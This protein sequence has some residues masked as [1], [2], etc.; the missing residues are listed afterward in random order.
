[1]VYDWFFHEPF[2]SIFLGVTTSLSLFSNGLLLYIVATTQSTHIG[3]YR[4]LL[5]VFAACDVTTAIG[6]AA[7]QPVSNFYM[8]L[9]PTGFYFF[10][11]HAENIIITE[12]FDTVFCLFF[13]ATYYQTFLILAYHFIYR[14]KT[15]TSGVSRSFTDGWSMRH[16]V[17]T[18]IVVYVLYIAGF[19]G[20][21]AIAFTPT[22]NSRYHR[23]NVPSEILDIYGIDLSDQRTG[24]TVISVK[25]WDS[26]LG[27]WEVHLPSILGLVLLLSLFGGTASAIVFCIYKTNAAIRS[28]DNH[29][30][31][32]TRKMQMGL[33]RA[34]LIQTAI[35]CLFSY[36]PLA[37][38][39]VFPAVS[40]ISLGAF[41][42]VLFSI[43]AI[44]PSIDA[45]FVL[46]FIAR[47]RTAV[48]RLFRLPINT[49]VSSS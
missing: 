34:L 35:P 8:H 16:W 49:S 9:T 25:Q 15:V 11:R 44:F 33:F 28:S 17:W 23:T 46:Y 32:K 29:L 1:P 14:Y 12:S 38:T 20:I 24:F 41:G 7:V 48:I 5:A 47:F 22:D 26:S 40:G 6:H 3:P 36:A 13:I 43:T 18:G 37:T 27:S 4:Y 39:L 30:T 19:V 31:A 10:P 21:C 2:H 42:N 45:F